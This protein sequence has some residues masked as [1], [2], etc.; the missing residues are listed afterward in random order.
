VSANP[1]SE[2]ASLAAVL[3]AGACTFL[4]VYVTQPLL[5]MFRR[6]FHASA[7][8]VSVTVSAT[9][10]G[11]GLA[12]PF[13][14]LLA[15][16][17]GR[18]RVIVPALFALSAPTLLAATAPNLHW[19]I[20]WRFLQGLFVPGIVAVMMAYINEEFEG[21]SVATW[22]SAY[23]A[24]TVF[25]GFL[26]RFVTG[27]VA[28]HTNW[29]YAFLVIGTLT[30]LGGFSVRAWL[31]K[32]ARF[33]KSESLGHA[34]RD[35][36]QHLRNPRLWANWA[37]GFS[38]L[39]C[40]VGMFTYVNF[41][42]AAPPFSL[43][44]AELGSVFFV[45]LLGVVVT[46]LAGRFQDR[47]GFRQTALIALALSFLGLGLTL[48][49][50]LPRIIAGL[51]LFSTAVFIWQAAATTQTGAVAGRAR[52]AAAGLYVTFYYLGGSVGG[53]VPAWFW[54]HHGWPGVV[55]VLAVAACASVLFGLGSG[56]PQ[57]APSPPIA[58]LH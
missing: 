25:G 10:L 37:M 15:E 33:R 2:R 53:V 7:L 47:R 43:N 30:L 1:Y 48:G 44:T 8:E 27:L 45:Y 28:Q 50:S 6:V 56:T 54:A 14:G 40:L 11:I 21:G 32:A 12:A 34:I 46:P 24:G 51:A 20:F 31:P 22:M 39:F 19:L 29:R 18:K 5:P 38:V 41:Y 58:V 9:T 3:I 4:N 57:T 36:L 26:G 49:H 35:G 23:I 16:R 52:S 42:L 17:I 13:F 55:G